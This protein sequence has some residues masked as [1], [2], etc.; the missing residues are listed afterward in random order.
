MQL[1]ESQIGVPCPSMFR[2]L[3]LIRSALDA[4]AIVA[5][6]D[7]KGD[8]IHVNDKFCEISKYD[9]LEL[10]GKNHR[11]IN[12][13][14]H[15]K[16][17]FIDMWKTIS[18][19]KKWEGE[20]KNRAKDGSFYWVHTTIVPFLDESNKPYQ[21]VSIRY[22]VTQKKQAEE[23]LHIYA[24]KLE[25][26]NRE[27]QKTLKAVTE[28]EAQILVQDRL[29]SVGLLASS[30]AHEIGTPLGVIRGR[31][32]II[33][34][35]LKDNIDVKKNIDIILAQID[36][37]S[38]LIRNLLNLARGEAS[39]DLGKVSLNTVL[40]EVLELMAH[41]FRRNNIELHNNLKNEVFVM[42]ESGPLHQVILNLLVNSVHAIVFAKKSGR[43]ENH[44][45]RIDLD[46]VDNKWML[47]VEDSGCGISKENLKNLFKPFFTTKDVGLGTGL[48]LATSYRIIEAWQGEIRVESEENVGCKFKILL[49]KA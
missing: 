15:G 44:F 32:E 36:R 10:L 19:G 30:L 49:P 5:I 18:K 6:T 7:R 2:E 23:Q 39:K 3:S 47:T 42:A 46:E 20:I 28:R 45:L 43:T 31:A 38:K 25:L 13:G 4:S 21:Y 27:L 40:V 14:Y 8:I 37:V 17:F 35:K 11:V 9:R 34:L 41:E 26:S 29:A 48:G 24:D 12:S 16:E 22:E 33:E 1:D